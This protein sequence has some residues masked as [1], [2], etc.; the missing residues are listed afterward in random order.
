MSMRMCACV[1]GSDENWLIMQKWEREREREREIGLINAAT[2]AFDKERKMQDNAKTEQREDAYYAKQWLLYCLSFSMCVGFQNWGWQSGTRER[3]RT[4]KTLL[5]ICDIWHLPVEVEVIDSA[6]THIITLFCVCV[7][8]IP[9]KGSNFVSLSTTFTF[10]C[11]KRERD[12]TNT[13][14]HL[15][16]PTACLLACPLCTTSNQEKGKKSVQI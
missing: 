16:M 11:D 13:Q 4:S 15:T 3:E 5:D 9:K 8:V 12:V 2:Y 14:N 10:S 1:W 7:C 6:H